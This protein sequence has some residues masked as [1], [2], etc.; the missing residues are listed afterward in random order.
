MNLPI[1][2]KFG[3]RKL[4]DFHVEAIYGEDLLVHSSGRIYRQEGKNLLLVGS[5]NT[6]HNP[7][8][9]ENKITWYQ[10]GQP[11]LF[12]DSVPFAEVM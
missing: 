8:R 6:F 1:R 5:F 12:Y 4:E 2:T 3:I 9:R 11:Q 10:S 7:T